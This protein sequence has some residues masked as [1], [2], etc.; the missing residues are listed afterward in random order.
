VNQNPFWKKMMFVCSGTFT[1]M[2]HIEHL[3][4][5]Y[6]EY[7]L[8]TTVQLERLKEYRIKRDLR[9]LLTTSSIPLLSGRD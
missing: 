1:Q 5:C 7:R 9:T 8:N 3:H 6:I 4:R 2:L